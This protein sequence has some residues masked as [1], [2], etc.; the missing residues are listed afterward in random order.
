MLVATDPTAVI[1]DSRCKQN[2]HRLGNLPNKKQDG[3]IVCVYNCVY[4]YT[5]EII[6]GDGKSDPHCV[7]R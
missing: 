2:A 6:S 3:E 4:I 5:D 1:V 7:L